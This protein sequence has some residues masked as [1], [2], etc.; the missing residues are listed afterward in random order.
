MGDSHMITVS[1]DNRGSGRRV[2]PPLTSTPISA[3]EG[4]PVSSTHVS[5]SRMQEARMSSVF[6]VCDGGP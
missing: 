3:L 5:T 1:R 2:S 4:E 6:I